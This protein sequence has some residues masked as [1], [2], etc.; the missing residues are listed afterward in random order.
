M[1]FFASCETEFTPPDLT[2]QL[3]E[4]TLT[5]AQMQAMARGGNPLTFSEEQLIGG[6]VT[7]SD[8]AGNFHRSF[9]IE[10]YTS[11]VEVLAGSY[12]LHTLYPVGRVVYVQLKGLTLARNE[13]GIWQLGYPG[14]SEQYAVEYIGGP[15]GL[16]DR[17]ITRAGMNYEFRIPDLTIGGLNA[18]LS[19]RLVT[20][21][22]LS[23]GLGG[24]ATWGTP[25]A[26]RETDRRA[27]EE[28]Y[29][30][31]WIYLRTS[32]YADFAGE[33][34]PAGTISVTGILMREQGGYSYILKIRDLNDVFPE[35]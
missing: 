7:A 8:G 24:E 18:A 20:V 28:P 22:G 26:G 11:A 5:I 29:Y 4:P 19:G 32:D 6:V 16:A 1:W 12:D 14:A 35:R 17:H 9:I 30:G 13:L 3:Q 34:L 25:G 10:D 31:R 15:S 27:N 2:P 21:H 23:M 33:T